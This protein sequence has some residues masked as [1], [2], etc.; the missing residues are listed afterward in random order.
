MPSKLY[1]GDRTASGFW[2]F[3]NRNIPKAF[4]K[5]SYDHDILPWVAEHQKKHRVLL[6]RRDKKT[7][8]LWK[9]LANKYQGQLE[10]AERRDRKAKASLMLGLEPGDKKDSKVLLY[11]AG[12]INPIVYPGIKKLDSLSKFLDSVLDG[13]ADLS[14]IIEET[15][16]EEF[17]L[18]ETE[19]EIERKQEAQRMALLHGGYTDLIDFEKALLA[20]GGGAG[21]HDTHGYGGVMGS[22]PEHMKKK[23][24]ASAS[25]ASTSS[26]ATP[27]ATEAPEPVV[28]DEI[29]D[30]K[31]EEISEQVV[32][33][34]V[35]D[36]DSVE[37]SQCKSA[38]SG[39]DASGG[40]AVRIKSTPSSRLLLTPARRC[41]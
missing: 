2:Y 21:Y 29:K 12:S 23:P 13:T 20:E 6:L 33:E 19:L 3:A 14:S 7:P 36:H 25:T 38:S 24:S 28:E 34:V 40:C 17:V 1:D 15:K 41:Q 8:L 30:V 10:F 5:I 35:K 11:P 39:Q 9:V 26:D 31:E 22:I 37:G 4:T 18:D 27:S 32:L 16:A